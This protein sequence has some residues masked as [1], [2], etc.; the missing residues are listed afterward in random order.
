MFKLAALFFTVISLNSFA[1]KESKLSLSINTKTPIYITSP[2]FLSVG[3]DTAQIVGSFWWDAEGEMTGGRGKNK[4]KPI[5]LTNPKLIELVS[6]L[7]PLYLRI[8]GSEADALYYNMKDNSEKRPKKYDSTLTK[9]RWQEIETFMKKTNAEL[10]FTLN[11]GPSSWDK[12]GKWNTDN[13]EEFL[14]FLKAESTI[15]F[16]LELGN[17][18]FAYWAIFGITNYLTEQEYAEN[19]RKAQKLFK[20]Y[21]IQTKLAGPASAYWPIIGEPLGF[22]FNKM[23][24][25]FPILKDEYDIVS[26][27]YYPTQSFRC[28]LAVRRMDKKRFLD[29]D[30]LDEVSKWGKEVLTLK[31]KYSPRAELW[32]GETGSA[33]CGGEPEISTE[34]ISSLW[35]ADH[36]GQLAR[37]K[38][39]VVV[40][41]NLIDAD[42]ALL[43]NDMAPRP[44]YHISWLW[45]KH[46]GTHILETT[47]SRQ[48]SKTLRAYAHCSPQKDGLSVFIIN[49]DQEER[50]LTSKLFT[51]SRTMKI[52]TSDLYSQ[53]MFI[54]KKPVQSLKD[55]K[56]I[57]FN[58]N[59]SEDIIAPKQS[60]VLVKISGNFPACQNKG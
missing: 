2:K 30:V 19:Y 27:H 39:D 4:T 40:R 20:K 32:L 36:L 48:N 16:K 17:E 57:T 25:L 10:F 1:N 8:G 33:Q 54:N 5:D 23:E 3:L 13:L 22:I 42:Y 38:H 7:S 35:W 28:P 41:H 26:W 15:P 52:T 53:K 29:P 9:K 44:D 24:D 49:I 31:E 6:E 18:V 58:Q 34:F 21:D 12:N 51:Q 14:T 37:L 43:N 50:T 11:Q 60:L 46:M 55:L 45:K 59:Q 47:L 56:A